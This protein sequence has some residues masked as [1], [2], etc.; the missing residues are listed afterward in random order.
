MQTKIHDGTTM[1]SEIFDLVHKSLFVLVHFTLFVIT[2]DN[3]NAP[4]RM[5][6]VQG[7]PEQVQ[8]VQAMIQDIVE[9]VNS[10]EIMSK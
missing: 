6:T 1:S 7:T 4:E 10:I 3:S 9:Q 5:A 2:E 8:K